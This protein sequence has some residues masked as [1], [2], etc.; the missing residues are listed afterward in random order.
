VFAKVT[1]AVVKH[2]DQKQTQERGSYLAYAST[3]LFINGEQELKKG[4]SL[5]AE[6]DAEAKEGCW[7][8]AY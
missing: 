3:A 4:R 6:T 8:A 5:E 7:L 2:H 1:T